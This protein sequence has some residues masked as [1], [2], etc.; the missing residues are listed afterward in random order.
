MKSLIPVLLIAALMPAALAHEGE[1]HAAPEAV[2]HADAARR[3]PDG[4]VFVP[5][6]VQRQWGLRTARAE[7]GEFPR[8]IELNGRVIADPQSGGRVQTLAAG[9]IEA[10]PKGIAVLGQAVKK[11][12]ILAQLLP[13]ASALERGS[14]Q[15]LLADLAAQEAVLSRRAERLKQLEGSV[16][17]KEI[18]Q[19]AIE[20][21]ALQQRRAAVAASLGP[22]ALRAP[23]DGVVAAVHVAVGQVVDARTVAF[24]VVDP[25]RLAVEALAYEPAVADG[26]GDATAVLPQG[27]LPLSFVGAARSL[28][29]QALP[30]LFRVRTGEGVPAVAVGQTLKVLATTRGR[31]PGVAVPTAA[32]VR[33]AANETVVWVHAAPEHFTPV[34]VQTQPLD[35]RRVLIT[36]GLKGGEPV[37]VQSAASLTQVR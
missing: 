23:V 34:R 33:N 13:A 27:T 19:A 22:E 18:E 25:A 17:Q 1:D 24:E 32:V 11:G 37:A 10:G 5:K 35:G 12:D 30:V 26:L 16:P 21:K 2:G 6:P 14:Q 36:Q 7:A 29:E 20:H 3:L 9:R 8:S 4:R 31:Q 15:A 28:R